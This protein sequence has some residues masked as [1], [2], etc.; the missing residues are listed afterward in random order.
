LCE[1]KVWA[2][3]AWLKEYAGKTLEEMNELQLD[4]DTSP[5]V[6]EKKAVA[7]NKNE[8]VTITQNLPAKKFKSNPRVYFEI[9]IG[10]IFFLDALVFQIFF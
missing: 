9:R 1:Y 10:R 8:K 3:D 4:D 6:I 2:D 7:N 5:A